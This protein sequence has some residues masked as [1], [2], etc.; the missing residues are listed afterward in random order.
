M[1][2]ACHTKRLTFMLKTMY[3]IRKKKKKTNVF[4]IPAL[5]T[6]IYYVESIHIQIE[7]WVVV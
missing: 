4:L 6:I 2:M 1:R 7:I 3:S 5:N